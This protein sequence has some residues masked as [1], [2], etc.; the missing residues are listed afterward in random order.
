MNRLGATALTLASLFEKSTQLFDRSAVLGALNASSLVDETVPLDDRNA[1]ALSLLRHG[2]SL[3]AA[4]MRQRVQRLVAG[5]T[6]ALAVEPAGRAPLPAE[7][8]ARR[9]DGP[10]DSKPVSLVRRQQPVADAALLQNVSCM[11]P[12]NGGKRYDRELLEQQ[13]VSGRRC[14]KG[15]CHDHCALALMDSVLSDAE[16]LRLVQHFEHVWE[17]E[18]RRAKRKEPAQGKRMIDLARSVGA[19]ASGDVALADHL[20]FVRIVE[21]VRVVT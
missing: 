13:I 19:V 18:S 9:A 15:A 2:L 6:A 4:A 14:S 10:A 3:E 7:L 1:L 8:V 17:K 11:R 16:C 21:R 12:T 20:F 5:S